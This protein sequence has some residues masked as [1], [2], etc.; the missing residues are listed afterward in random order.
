MRQKESGRQTAESD[1]AKPESQEK[2]AD[3]ARLWQQASLSF[4][5]AGALFAWL[6]IQG[7]EH[8]WIVPLALFESVICGGLVGF[9]LVFAQRLAKKHIFERYGQTKLARAAAC[10]MLFAVSAAFVLLVWLLKPN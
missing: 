2:R 7:V 9:G 1:G 10:A 4:L 5:I 3:N 6:L 8:V